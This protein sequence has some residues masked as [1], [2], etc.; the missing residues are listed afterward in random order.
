[1]RLEVMVRRGLTLVGCCALLMALGVAHAVFPREDGTRLPLC[2][3]LSALLADISVPA[4]CA[5][6]AADLAGQH[7]LERVRL[8]LESLA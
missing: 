2:D 7:A 1:M 4:A 3:A 8:A 6:V 5:R